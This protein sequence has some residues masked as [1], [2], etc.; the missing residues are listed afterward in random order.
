M[1]VA[2]QELVQLSGGDQDLYDALVSQVFARF[3]DEMGVS[4]VTGY[5]WANPSEGAMGPPIVMFV[6]VLSCVQVIIFYTAL[7]YVHML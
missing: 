6:S 2:F 3:A 7:L 4:D 1:I 5:D